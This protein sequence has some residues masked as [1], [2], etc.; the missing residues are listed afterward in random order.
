L[1]HNKSCFV[2]G[3]K[4]L[5]GDGIEK[6]IEEILV[7]DIVVS[8]NELESSVET[9]N[10]TEVYSPTHDDLIELLLSDGTKIVSTFDHPYYV[11]NMDLAS[12]EPKWTNERY[13]LPTEVVKIEIGNQ[14]HK[15]NGEKLE[16]I[17]INE[18]ERV[19]TQTYII[20]VEGN[21][22]FYLNGILVHNK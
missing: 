16:I 4:V 2:A 12:Y 11:N 22:N 9:R 17:S 5:M 6:N 7:G 13:K 18:L 15:H 20:S 8:Y 21:R 14:V 19:Q 3:S 1:T 10:V